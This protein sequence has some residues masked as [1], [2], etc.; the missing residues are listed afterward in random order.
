[1]LHFLDCF[2]LT[3]FLFR[4]LPAQ[5]HAERS[6]SEQTHI[7]RSRLFDFASK[8]GEV[9]KS[10]FLPPLCVEQLP[11]FPVQGPTAAAFTRNAR[12]G[13]TRTP[14]TPFT[15][16]A[17]R[18][19]AFL[20]IQPP[21]TSKLCLSRELWGTASPCPSSAC[22]AHPCPTSVVFGVIAVPSI[23]KCW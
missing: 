22:R 19:K 20:A 2:C 1:M 18:R 9:R 13:F 11:L 10:N 14:P 16:L 3:T 12:Q 17:G 5:F 8:E 15:P 7:P 4:F 21:D 23:P 6:S